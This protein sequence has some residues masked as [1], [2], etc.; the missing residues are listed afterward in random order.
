MLPVDLKGYPGFEA[1][2][3]D[4][5][6]GGK[7]LRIA[8][9]YVQPTVCNGDSLF[10]GLR[11]LDTLGVDLLLGDFNAASLAW[12][13][14]ATKLGPAMQRFLG[15]S[16]MVLLAPGTRTH[17]HGST[18]DLCIARARLVHAHTKVS[19]MRTPLGS[20]HFPLIVQLTRTP[21]SPTYGRSRTL[22]HLITTEHWS[23]F[24]RFLRRCNPDAG[25]VERYACAMDS[26][27]AAAMRLLP[28]GIAGGKEYRFPHP[29]AKD[30]FANARRAWSR[31]E[32]VQ[33]AALDDLLEE[34][35]RAEATASINSNP[36][37]YWKRLNR[38]SNEAPLTAP[39]GSLRHSPVG[40]AH[41][42]RALY[43]S[44][45]EQRVPPPPCPDFPPDASYPATTL[46]EVR[47]AIADQKKDTAADPGGIHPLC[48]DHLPRA[49]L[50]HLAA[51]ATRC[52]REGVCPRRWCDATIIPIVKSEKLGTSPGDYR[53]VSMTVLLGRI[54]ER[55]AQQRLVEILVPQLAPYQYGFRKGVGPELPI[56]HLLRTASDGFATAVRAHEWECRTRPLHQKKTIVVAFD[57]SD[58]FCRPSRQR[59]ALLLE[60]Y[61]VP[62]TLIRFILSFLKNRRI[63][64]RLGKHVTKYSLLDLGCPQGG[65]LIPLLW[66]LFADPLA[67]R[68]AKVLPAS[69]GRAPADLAL[70]ADDITVWATHHNPALVRASLNKLLSIMAAW[71]LEEGIAISDKT[72]ALI[73][74]GTFR[75]AVDDWALPLQRGDGVIL[76]PQRGT[77]RILGVHID[78]SLTFVDHADHIVATVSPYLERL[79]LL[80]SR[81]SLKNLR[82]LYIGSVLSR[83]TYAATA[84]W[85]HMIPDSR[86][87]LHVL[88]RQFARVIGGTIGS[89][90]GSASIAEANMSS[91]LSIVAKSSCQRASGIARLQQT[92]PAAKVV[93][94]IAREITASDL[95][96]STGNMASFWLNPILQQREPPFLGPLVPAANSPHNVRIHAYSDS[97]ISTLSPVATR[98]AE[99]DRR[100]AA[101]GSC[102]FL[103][104][105]D[106]GVDSETGR[107]VGGALLTD[108][109]NN[110]IASVARS[111]GPL[112]CS[113]S[114]EYVGFREGLSAL[115]QRVKSLPPSQ[116]KRRVGVMSD[117]QSLLATLARGPLRQRLWGC[118]DI[119]LC[120]SEISQF[121]DVSVAFV[122]AH[123]GTAA[124]EAVDAFVAAALTLATPP[125]APLWWCDEARPK[126]QQIRLSEEKVARAATPFRDAL[127]KD[128]PW[129][130]MPIRGLSRCDERLLAQLRSGVCPLLGGWKHESPDPCPRCLKPGAM[131]RQGGSVTHAFGCPSTVTMRST[132]GVTEGLTTLVSDPRAALKYIRAF[133]ALDA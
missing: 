3:V 121:V 1:Q 128:K 118:A 59:I 19:T 44:K 95:A 126:W 57:C 79:K 49:F 61:N 7:C 8:N 113:F 14:K 50:V 103:L 109:G 75:T 16:T 26:C 46:A 24:S 82:Q 117:S 21:R 56:A 102:D 131:C 15:Q 133:V 116:P 55:T 58:A 106:G 89:A 87:K 90:P 48:L 2:V 60:E 80:K 47:S 127:L 54:V 124:N 66:I 98:A 43:V 104:A 12:S 120:L 81:M 92:F 64:V 18:I 35:L 96:T 53:P 63:R 129:L 23:R 72:K 83:M 6:G 115:L 107:A 30:T 77:I 33:G 74:S 99:N 68:L 94:K 76:V 85:P 32:D 97:P 34:D 67:R 42:L 62:P 29:G 20:D 123:V 13:G 9:V 108:S 38:V 119:W 112:A 130:P 5:R 78:T 69:I 37:G 105:T 36:W 17:V 101:F 40:K 70:F 84:W 51:L 122:F 28:S 22:W 114:A 41:L 125:H 45:H 93:S 88:H 65:V 25:T 11:L 39:D 111:V 110:L 91:L 10:A 52:M 31:D 73:L 27:Y 132:L 71:A 4:V 100:I 86:E